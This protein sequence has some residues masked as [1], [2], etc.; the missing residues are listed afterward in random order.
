M[1]VMEALP[2]GVYG[3]QTN[4]WTQYMVCHYA[5]DFLKLR[6]TL[7]QHGEYDDTIWNKWQSALKLIAPCNIFIAKRDVFKEHSEKLLKI[8]IDVDAQIDTKGRDNYQKRA[9]SF[10]LERANSY[11]CFKALA[12]GKW[13]IAEAKIEQH[14]DW[15]PAD[16]KDQRGLYTDE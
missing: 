7:M 15:K 11:L 5:S 12:E 8:G 14:L 2:L 6:N 13:R 16:A 10:I 9:S 3:V 4:V 1:L